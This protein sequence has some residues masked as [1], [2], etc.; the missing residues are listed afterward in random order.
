MVMTTRS[1]DMLTRIRNAI[2]F[3]MIKVEVPGSK[4]KTAIVEDFE[5]RGF[6]KRL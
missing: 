2:R 4:I 1:A 5:E 3:I 6:Y